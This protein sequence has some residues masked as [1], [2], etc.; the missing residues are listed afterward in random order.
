LKTGHFVRRRYSTSSSDRRFAISR[1][2]LANVGEQRENGERPSLRQAPASRGQRAPRLTTGYLD[3]SRLLLCQTRLALVD[4]APMLVGMVFGRFAG[5]VRRMKTVPVSD[6][7]VV[8]CLLVIAGF[9]VTSGF[10]MVSR[11]VFVVFCRLFVV[12]GAFVI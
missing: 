7:R 6:M 5:V 1:V 3:N 10:A 8:P 12:V 2:S 11:C 9:M 4:V